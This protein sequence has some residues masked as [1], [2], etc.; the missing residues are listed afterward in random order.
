MLIYTHS[1]YHQ[2]NDDI[3]LRTIPE[4]EF[5]SHLQTIMSAEV[6]G[7]RAAGI[8]TW[9]E[10]K[11]WVT[12]SYRRTRDGRNWAN[13]SDKWSYRRSVFDAERRDGETNEAML[14]RLHQRNY[15]IV[16]E[17]LAGLLNDRAN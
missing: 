10:D 8:V 1:R 4:A 12:N 11:Y 2:S 14:D 9:G 13:D 3:G 15:R 17:T 7:R 5:R 6:N 16:H